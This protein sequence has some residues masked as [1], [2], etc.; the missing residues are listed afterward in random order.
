MNSIQF[1]FAVHNHQP[2][3]N[4]DS[5][6]EEAFQRC[7]RPFIDVLDRHPSIKF[8]Q[9]WTG[10]LLEWLVKTHPEFIERLHAMVRRG[11]LELLTGAYYEAILAVIPER[12]RIGQIKKLTAA[13]R[14]RFGTSPTGLWLAERVWEQQ[15][16]SSLVRA[17]VRS[18]I[19]DDTH[20]RHA[21]L[22]EEQLLGYYVTEEQGETLSVLPINKMLRYTIP[23]RSVQET[24]EYLGRSA[25]AEGRNFVL[26]ADDGEKFGVWPKTYTSVYEEGWLESFCAM[27]TQQ[28]AWIRTVHIEEVLAG[29]PPLGRIYLPAASYH[30][31]MKWA[32]DAHAFTHL[33]R[34]EEALK[35]SGLLES[36]GAFVR[37]GFWRNFLAKYPEAN[38]MHKKMLRI[39]RR[40]ESVG[41]HGGVSARV[42]DHLWAGQCN[43]A[44]WH[45]VFGGLYLPNLRYPVYH[46]LLQAEAALD[47]AQKL[48]ALRVESTD[49]DCDGFPEILLES[50]LLNL[51]F[52]PSD[53]GCLIELDYKS[54][55]IN[56]LDIVSRREEGYHRRLL[57]QDRYR[58]KQN[59]H[60]GVL[61][62]E[63]HLEQ[64]LTVDWYRRA[65]YQDHFLGLGATLESLAR[66][67]YP[68]LGDFVNQPYVARSEK[69]GDEIL[70]TLERNGA[71]WEGE[72][73][74]RLTVRK[75][76]RYVAGA[77]QFTVDY[78]V[79]NREPEPREIWFAV[80]CNT[81]LMAGDAHDRY[82]RIPG[83]TLQ[84]TRLRASGE[85]KSVDEVELVDEWLKVRTGWRLSRPATLWRYPIETVSLSEQGFER[86]YQS[87]TTLFHWKT[88]L[89]D[90]FTVRLTQFVGRT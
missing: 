68:E 52:K 72:S 7:Y 67:H 4:F 45:G 24:V 6:F 85:E 11:Q 42:L 50:D 65:S 36:G 5:V 35:E 44:Y 66:C 38:Q 34:F 15:L 75:V 60:E 14:S 53:G 73:H 26:H 84:D 81:G 33:E 18:V 87:S 17:G 1:T 3:G 8:T 58:E 78:T 82:C 69:H 9:H 71:I 12:D 29:T 31:M 57:E 88:I 41:T 19:I 46:N 86:L 2:I 22:R 16:T 13:L 55:G 64:H 23:F 27:L 79:I 70:I 74:H 48:P 76:V 89:V 47:H 77:R 56:F 28:S 20:F 51:Y 37:G 62:K 39:S 54:A 10:P 49:F 30:E 59:I 90:E 40:C 25:S 32:L 63:E 43:D 83:R 61:A 80:E 21:G